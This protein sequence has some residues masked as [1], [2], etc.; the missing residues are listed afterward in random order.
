MT[1]THTLIRYAPKQ[2]DCRVCGQTWQTKPR[3]DCPGVMVYPQFNCGNLMTEL[4]LD[5]SGYHITNGR[6]PQ[7]AGCYRDYKSNFVLLYDPDQA[8]KKRKRRRS[9]TICVSEIFWPLN[10]VSFLETA[11]YWRKNSASAYHQVI[12]EVA[13]MAF[14]FLSFTSEEMEKHAGGSIPLRIPPILLR[15]SFTQFSGENL[16]RQR[17]ARRI[18]Y[19]YESQRLAQ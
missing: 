1:Q 2:Y 14:Q 13:E 17:F 15:R 6:L 4:Q 10:C 11:M 16:E 19:A 12:N 5:W 8:V 9:A 7:P 3:S 18:L